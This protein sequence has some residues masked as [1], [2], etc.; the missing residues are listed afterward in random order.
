SDSP[1]A[2]LAQAFQ[3]LIRPLLGKDEAELAP[4]RD[5][6]L[7]ALGPSARL[8]VDLVP[9]LKLIIGDQPPV[10]ELSPQAAQW[11]F[12]LLFRRFIGVFARPEHPLALFLDDLQ[13]IDA[14]TLDLLEDLLTRSD[15]KHLMLIG[16]YR[17][18]EVVATHPLRRK[19]DA[20]KTAGG[21]VAEITLAPLARAHLGQL[22]ADALRCESQRAAPLARLLHEKTGG[23]PFFAIQFISSLAEEGIL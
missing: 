16:A 20:I 1:F 21:K 6:L 17:D 19:L 5:A 11:R 8:M 2:T 13:W 9:E 23:N 14:A 18:N 7:E 12:K 22:I 10:H 4:W 15:V 3:R